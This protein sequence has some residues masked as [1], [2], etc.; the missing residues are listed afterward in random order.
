MDKTNRDE[1]KASVN[2]GFSVDFGAASLQFEYRHDFGFDDRD[3]AD[4]LSASVRIPL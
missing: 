4:I 2:G 1:D 3:S